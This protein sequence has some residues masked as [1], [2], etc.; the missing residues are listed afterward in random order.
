MK[1]Y[2]KHTAIYLLILLMLL[3]YS[4]PF[5]QI[6]I[7]QEITYKREEALIIPAGKAASPKNYNPFTTA[8]WTARGI[9]WINEF[10][11]H[12]NLLNDTTFGWLATGYEYGPKYEYIKIFLRKGVT[13]NDGVPFTAHDIVFTINMLKKHPELITAP[14][15]IKWIKDIKAIGDHE[16]I[17]WL[18]EPNVRFHW[19]LTSLIC[20]PWLW[21]VPKHIWEK[22]EDPSKFMNFPPVTTGPYKVIKSTAEEVILERD[23]NYWGAKILG[24]VPQPKYV[25]FKYVG[26]REKVAMALEKNE[27]DVGGMSY[28]VFKEAQKRNPH[29]IFWGYP[30]P[31][32][33][34]L[35]INIHKY[36]L[37]LKEVRWAISYAINRTKLVFLLEELAHPAHTWFPDYKAVQK[38]IDPK[39][40]EKYDTTVHDPKKSINILKNLGFTRGPDGVWVTPN[41]T[42]LEFELQCGIPAGPITLAICEDLTAI[43]IKVTPKPLEWAVRWSNH[44][45]LHYDLWQSWAQF[46]AVTTPYTWYDHFSSKYLLPIGQEAG[47]GFN[48]IRFKNATYD[49]ILSEVA[50]IPDEDPRAY[51][52]YNKLLEILLQELPRIPLITRTEFVILN[53]KYW[54]N[55]PS[56]WGGPNPYTQAQWWWS[57]FEFVFFN[58]RSRTLPPVLPPKIEYITVWFTKHV[59]T[60]TGA[61]GKTYGPFDAGD[62]AKIPQSDAITL[63]EKRLA[64]K[65]PPLPEEAEAAMKT[66]SSKV[67]EISK[68]IS[69]L[70]SSV[71]ESISGL[72]NT[73]AGMS[74]AIYIAIILSLIAAIAAVATLIRSRSPA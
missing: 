15:A 73:V 17:I 21:I 44:A 7:A 26:E 12:Y 33:S 34:L 51:K 22:V 14:W 62:S 43:G 29:L 72:A 20:F 2:E 3:P 1:K 57:K 5:V 30:T 52:L 54:T 66:L 48:R 69:D 61:D 50:K 9:R 10:L 49:A 16:V 8:G 55:W 6:N 59:D 47:E 35:D 40:I 65:V 56:S 68:D 41:G 31:C 28:S 63:I 11:F 74:T 42:R 25:I 24:V 64:S 46:P 37:S 58:I 67:D 13:W 45:K 60:F 70:K 27:L 36:P 23:P 53:D 71:Q 4:L 18:N 39:I 38:F 19:D 32:P